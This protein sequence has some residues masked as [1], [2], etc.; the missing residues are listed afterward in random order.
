M[1][2][3]QMKLKGTLE[4]HQ[5]WVTQIA[6]TTQNGKTTVISASRDNT[7]LV[8]DVDAYGSDDVS[9]GRPVRSLTGHSHFV[10]DVV[11]SSDGMFALSGS[12]D[13]TLRLW[14]LQTGQTTR[15]FV[16]HTK[17]VLSVAFSADNRQIVSGSRDKSIKLWNT[18]AQ[19][20][21]TITE[22]CHSDWVS[23][24]RFSPSTRDPVIVSAGWDKVVKVWNLGNC[25][26]KTNHIGHTGYVNSVTV[27]PDGSLCASGGK[28]GS[29]MLWDLN[30]GKHLYTLPGNDVMNALTFSPNRYWLCA[31]IGGTIKI[32][33]LEDKQV[34][35]ELKP[36]VSVGKNS[37][38]PICTSLCWSQDGQTLYA[39]YSDKIIRVWQ[40]CTR[41]A[42]ALTFLSVRYMIKYLDPNY[43]QKEENEKKVADLF[44]RLG[45]PEGTRIDLNEHEMRIALQLVSGEEESTTW[46]DIGGADDIIEDLKD[47]VILPLQLAGVSSS[48]LLNPPRG[49]LLYGPPGCGKTLLAK[50]VAKASG[51]RFI[52]LQ[53][54]NLTDKWYGE[55]QK[56]AAAVFSVAQKLQP[57]IIFL[58]EIDSFLRDRQAHDHEATAMMKAQFMQLWDGFSSSSD[59]IIVMGATNRPSDVDA[60][61]LRRMP[62]KFAVNLPNTV[63]RKQIFEVILNEERCSST[64]DLARL[65]GAAEGLSGSDLKEVC[66][67]A[68]LRRAKES[69][70]KKKREKGD[71]IALSVLSRDPIEQSD[72]ES[73]L[74]HY[75]RSQ[76]QM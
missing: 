33:N 67:I 62:A 14:D 11:I 4:G 45:L 2:D 69:L 3:E 65:A 32:W 76:G 12:W 70:D 9:I 59:Q 60:A 36:D 52:N 68:V 74:E 21:Y 17:D 15:R 27:S 16:S 54:S 8:W 7:V 56:L 63:Q 6:T 71:A 72:L 26:L 25:R 20:K 61:I 42:S 22:D 64:V 13:K 46:E 41:P 58:D 37:T 24:V 44:N 66:R 48:S 23:T 75:M 53:V 73:A 51:C 40:V 39:G 50:A 57:T 49:I 30:E 34:I 43:A 18:L 55:S 5:G 29:A 38:P 19:C 28:D 1:S 31:A 10:S 35:E 47:R